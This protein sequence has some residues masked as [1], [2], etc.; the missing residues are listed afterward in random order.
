[1][2]VERGADS[3]AALPARTV[4]AELKACDASRPR[5]PARRHRPPFVAL[6]APPRGSATRAD[7]AHPVSS[8]WAHPKRAR[9]SDAVSSA[10]PCL[11]RTGKAIDVLL[12]MQLSQAVKRALAQLGK[13]RG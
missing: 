1:M 10:H 5:E 9:D 3:D 2:F 13:V 6:Q 7:P 12:A 4:R 11:D 8:R